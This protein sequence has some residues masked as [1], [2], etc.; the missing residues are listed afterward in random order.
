MATRCARSA[1]IRPMP[2]SV[3][4]GR[5]P[6]VPMIAVMGAARPA[7]P[8]GDPLGHVEDRRD[9]GLVVGEVHDDDPG[10]EPVQVEPPR[11]AF[12]R[13]PEVDEAVVRPRSIVAPRPRAP[14]AAASALATLW[15]ASPPI[16]IGTSPISHDRGLALAL[17]LDQRAAPDDVRAATTRPGAGGRPAERLGHR[18]EGDPRPHPTGDRGHVA[19]RRR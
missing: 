7:A 18:E 6:A 9:A 16:V 8:A 3:S 12:G 1:A 10:A 13:R 2:R 19:G 4:S 14:P 17:G 15:R 5:S 11:R